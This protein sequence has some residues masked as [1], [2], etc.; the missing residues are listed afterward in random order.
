MAI[1]SVSLPDEMVKELDRL[2]DIMGT[3]RSEV[4]RAGIRE[5]SKI[6]EQQLGEKSSAILTVTHKDMHDREVTAIKEGQEELI[7]THMHSKIDAER[8]VDVFMLD[9]PGAEIRA[10]TNTFLGNKKMDTVELTLL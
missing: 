5:M 7:K 4:I 6:Q 3:G 2:Q 1:I 9:G 8:C 10:V